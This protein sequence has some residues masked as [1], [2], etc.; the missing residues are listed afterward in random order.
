MDDTIHRIELTIS[1][2]GLSTS[3]R[4]INIVFIG[5]LFMIAVN[6]FVTF[7]YGVYIVLAIY[8]ILLG[9]LLICADCFKLDWIHQYCQFLYTFMGRGL[10]HLL[11]GFTII[12]PQYTSYSSHGF[13]TPVSIIF[14]VFG[15][16]HIIGGLQS[17]VPYPKSVGWQFDIKSDLREVD[18][19]EESLINNN[20]SRSEDVTVVEIK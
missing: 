18:E 5:L 7:H 1:K 11:C 12:T 4:M 3:I 13:T 15:V 2:K 9:I 19:Y 20:T 14:L 10:L 8:Y 6:Y 17:R 16:A